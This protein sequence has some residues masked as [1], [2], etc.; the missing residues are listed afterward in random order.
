MSKI[1]MIILARGG[2]LL[3]WTVYISVLASSRKLLKKRPILKT[4]QNF[5]DKSFCST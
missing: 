3:Y 4:S 1:I 2:C 5:W